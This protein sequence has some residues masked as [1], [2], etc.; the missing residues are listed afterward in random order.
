MERIPKGASIASAWPQFSYDALSDV[1]TEASLQIGEAFG[2][3]G[4]L[5]NPTLVHNVRLLCLTLPFLLL[6]HHHRKFITVTI[7]KGRE[8]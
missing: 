7:L 6:D 8:L 5:L 1:R 4:F 3:R 2:S